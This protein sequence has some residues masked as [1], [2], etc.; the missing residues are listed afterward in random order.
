MASELSC[1]EQAV[2]RIDYNVHRR[3][4][5]EKGTKGITC[6]AMPSW[7]FTLSP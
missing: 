7:K 1:T 2:Q 6:H 3:K 5:F 4:R